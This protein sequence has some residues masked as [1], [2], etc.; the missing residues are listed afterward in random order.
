MACLRRRPSC[1]RKRRWRQCRGLAKRRWQRPFSKPRSTNAE[2]A[3]WSILS[4]TF[5]ERLWK[6]TRPYKLLE[7]QSTNQALARRAHHQDFEPHTRCKVHGSCGCSIQDCAF[8]EIDN[9]NPMNYPLNVK[10]EKEGY[11]T[12]QDSVYALYP[13]QGT[14]KLLNS[15]WKPKALLTRSSLCCAFSF[16][17]SEHIRSG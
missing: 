11:S 7:R 8:Q 15:V 9:A 3:T 13:Q 5:S 4:S 14:D 17:L 12:K 10:N 16:L 2:R 1:F 6:P